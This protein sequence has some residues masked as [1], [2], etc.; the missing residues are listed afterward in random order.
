M[1][2]CLKCENNISEQISII[3]CNVTG[4]VYDV[5]DYFSSNCQIPSACGFY[6]EIN[7]NEQP[8]IEEYEND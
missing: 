4:K 1:S 8:K 5:F 7:F 6:K 2:D 3:Y